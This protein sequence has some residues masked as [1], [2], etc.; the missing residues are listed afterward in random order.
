MTGGAKK[1]DETM[2]A[3][4]AGKCG[5]GKYVTAG[6][7]VRFIGKKIAK[8]AGCAAFGPLDISDGE[9]GLGWIWAYRLGSDVTVLRALY[10]SIRAAYLALAPSIDGWGDR[11]ENR[12]GKTLDSIRGICGRDYSTTEEFDTS[13]KTAIAAELKNWGGCE[14]YERLS[15]A[16]LF[17][18]HAAYTYKAAATSKT[19]IEPSP[20]TL[21]WGGFLGG[22]MINIDSDATKALGEM[23]AI[24]FGEMTAIAF[25]RK[26]AA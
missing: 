2:E 16:Q 24:A 3:R 7:E 4:Y 17:C 13:I 12:H 5:C 20:E 6:D 19:W 18:L 21:S 23:T 11:Q 15:I 14:S 9:N 26:Q 1:E 25:G 10:R 8:C 22:E